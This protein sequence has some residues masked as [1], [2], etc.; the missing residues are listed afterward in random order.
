M[1]AHP[2]AFVMG[3]VFG[4]V[5]S[6]APEFAQQY[7]QRLGGAVDE[8]QR[9]IQ[10][11]D[12]DSRHS[13]YDRTAALRLMASN[14]EKLVRDQAV[15]MEDVIARHDRLRAQEIAF[16][17]GGPFVRISAFI[18][19]FDRPLVQRTVV[20]YEPAVPVTT[21]G[22]L[23]AGGGFLAAYLLLP[24]FGES[25]RRRRALRAKLRSSMVK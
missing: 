15:R 18:L 2:V 21:E 19:N 23:L 11:F 9:I 22:L 16:Q 20:A 17:N 7:R 13:G 24:A 5:L 3:L 6:Q 14:N 25:W 4:F 12:E 8:L 1:R 10:Q